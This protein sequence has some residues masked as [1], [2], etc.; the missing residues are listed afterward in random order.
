MKVAILLPTWVGDTCMATPTIRAIKQGLPGIS[1]LCLVGRYAPVAVL[2]GSPWADSSL[3]YKPKSK[4]SK[5]LSRRGMIAELKKRKFDLMV[6]LPNSLSAGLIGYFSGAKRR[7]GYVKDGRSWLLTDRIPLV[8]SGVDQR[9][10]STI[11]YYLNIAQHLGC[12]SSDRSMELVVTDRDRD[13]SMQMFR[14]WGFDWSRPTVVFNTASASGT[15]RLWP[16]GHASRAAA[17]LAKQHGVQV[18]IHS[19]P[20]DRERANAIEFGASHGL[21]RSM[22]QLR[23]I[24][25]GLSK[26]V[27]Q[28]ANVVLSTDSGPRHMAVALNQRVVS[29]FGPTAPEETATYNRPES[30]LRMSMECSP[31]GKTKCPLVHNNCMHGLGYTQVVRAVM[32]RLEET[33]APVTLTNLHAA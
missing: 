13:Q 7:V 23:D 6:L 12:A 20:A 29:L 15:A 3:V 9:K 16:V 11:E 26:A 30:I 21:V 18:V 25:V 8:Q 5:T 19:G 14:D 22:G 28:Q 10:R 27:L 33:S 32:Q 31:C 1:E 17:F 2:E 4:D 24:P